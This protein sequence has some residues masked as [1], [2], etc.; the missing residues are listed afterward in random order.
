[1]TKKLA[2]LFLLFSPLAHLSA[3]NNQQAL[4]PQTEDLKRQLKVF[5]DLLKKICPSFLGRAFR[6]ECLSGNVEACIDLIKTKQISTQQALEELAIYADDN[7]LAI[8][9]KQLLTT[10]PLGAFKRLRKACAKGNDSLFKH[11]LKECT[12]LCHEELPSLPTLALKVAAKNKQIKLSKAIIDENIKEFCNTKEDYEA[13]RFFISNCMGSEE[14]V[15]YL[16]AKAKK[17]NLPIH[18]AH[19]SL[20]ILKV[21]QL[22]APA[23]VGFN[24]LP[25]TP[26]DDLIKAIYLAGS[27]QNLAGKTGSWLRNK[28]VKPGNSDVTS[29]DLST[30]MAESY[31]QLT[32]AAAMSPSLLVLRNFLKPLQEKLEKKD[33]T[34]TPYSLPILNAL[35]DSPL[36]HLGIKQAYLSVKKDGIYGVPLIKHGSTLFSKIASFKK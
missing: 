18:L 20:Q 29:F 28:L 27:L 9:G 11:Y 17:E 3:S 26:F 15:T 34:I 13:L 36:L 21:L 6:S 35:G 24:S 33:V 1:M 8:V 16:V 19:C 31:G 25:K 7:T 30:T 4:S 14:A 12:A 10:T 23:I 2:L 5:T 32:Q 22:W